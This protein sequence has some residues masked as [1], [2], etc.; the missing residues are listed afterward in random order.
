MNQ[1]GFNSI[2]NLITMGYGLY[3]IYTWF[4]LLR[5]PLFSNPLLI[6]KDLAPKDCLDA[7]SYVT[8]IRPRTLVLGIIAAL[9]GG[10]GLAGEAAGFLPAVAASI[11]L[12]ANVF[13]LVFLVALPLA[14]VIWY[15]VC[16]VRSQRKYFP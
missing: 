8:Y 10:V 7:A 1:G 14:V 15:A 16:L 3:A 9:S 11:G 13:Q 6:P 12:D 4:R 5:E 2:F